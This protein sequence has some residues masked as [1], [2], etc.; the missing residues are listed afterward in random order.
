[1]VLSE[2]S[3]ANE[4][5]SRHRETVITVRDQRSCSVVHE[6]RAFGHYFAA[7]SF[8]PAALTCSRREDGLFSIEV[9]VISGAGLSQKTEVSAYAG[10]H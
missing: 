8:H 7:R 2:D 10:A 6:F 1:L 5:A 9:A 3:A 4:D